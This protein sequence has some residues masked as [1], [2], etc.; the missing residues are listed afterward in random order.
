MAIIGKCTHFSR[1]FFLLIGMLWM[2][3]CEQQKEWCHLLE[4]PTTHF[5]PPYPEI[6]GFDLTPYVD[7]THYFGYQV[8]DVLKAPSGDIAIAYSADNPTAR[9]GKYLLKLFFGGQERF[10]HKSNYFHVTECVLL[11][12]FMADHVPIHLKP[13]HWFIVRQNFSGN[14]RDYPWQKLTLLEQKTPFEPNRSLKE[15][16]PSTSRV[17]VPFYLK[18]PQK[19]EELDEAKARDAIQ[20]LLGGLIPLEDHSFLTLIGTHLVRFKPNFT[21]PYPLE[22]PIFLLEEKTLLALYQRYASSKTPYLNVIKSLMAY[23][24]ERR[25]LLLT[26]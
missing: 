10:I 2:T 11:Q 19:L 13:N 14:Q 4:A 23:P 20:P 3:G 21:T 12:K 26:N 7:H 5:F 1:Y 18:L 17:L 25:N 9:K 16:Y 8:L 15:C 22:M 6:W 24:V